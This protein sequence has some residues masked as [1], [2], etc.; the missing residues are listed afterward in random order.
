M[1]ITALLKQPSSS[2]KPQSGMPQTSTPSTGTGI[3]LSGSQ[4]TVHD[5]LLNWFRDPQDTKPAVFRGYAGVG[6]TTTLVELVATI[7]KHYPNLP[8]GMT[9]PTHKAVK[10]M[11]KNGIKG[12]LYRTIHSMLGIKEVIDYTTG[13]IK[14]KP[15][16]ANKL[17]PPPI[18]DMKLLILDETSMLSDELF[19]Y[20]VPYI[21]KGLKV[22]FTGD[23]AQIPPVKHVDCIP[24]RNAEHWGMTS[25]ELTEV[26]RQKNG[27]PILEF[28][29]A[30]RTDYK[31]GS[32]TP[33]H[34]LLDNGEGIHVVEHA[35]AEE[36]KILEEYFSS[37]KFKQDS[38]YMKVIAWMNRTVDKYNERIRSILFRDHAHISDV[39]VGEKMLMAHPFAISA[40]QLLTRNEEVEVKD[41]S[42][43]TREIMTHNGYGVKTY[44]TVTTY[45]TKLEWFENGGI[46]LATVPI[47]HEQSKGEYIKLME[48]LKSLAI[49]ADPIRRTALWKQFYNVAEMFAKV[50]YNYAVTAHTSQGSTYDNCLVLKWD[51]DC[52]Q[53][54]EERNRILYVAATRARNT[55]FI[56]I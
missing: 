19:H 23:P 10:V 8:I 44:I 2:V 13:E 36:D 32:F 5:R 14:Y 35:S 15:D 28:A 3:I 39:M 24:F 53:N 43:V 49:S 46:K 22:L 31:S 11:R 20:L 25:V 38:D 50:K 6:K 30:I 52:N 51:I 17:E 54:I 34:H 33:N 26:I 42:T 37:P 1:D 18:E 41:V 7:L 40:R 16:T 48:E 45:M 55:L 21:K 4:Q 27:N 12:V 9:A 47:L 56:E 29:T